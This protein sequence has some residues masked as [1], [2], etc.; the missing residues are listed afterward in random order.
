MTWCHT[1]PF[2]DISLIILLFTNVS[3]T[4]ST[5]FQLFHLYFKHF[6]LCY[7]S[8]SL[9]CFFSSFSHLFFFF[10]VLQLHFQCF[11]SLMYFS[12]V[13]FSFEMLHCLFYSSALSCSCLQC[14]FYLSLQWEKNYIKTNADH[15]NICLTGF[16][17]WPSFLFSLV[18]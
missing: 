11:P 18:K 7:H 9:S 17:L 16:E 15:I 5:L 14:P 8:F 4:P 2:L 3:F 10:Y 6:L 1:S 13:Y 12:H